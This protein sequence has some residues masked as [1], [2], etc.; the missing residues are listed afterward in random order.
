MPKGSKPGERR[1]GRQKGTTN[2]LTKALKDM[3]LGALD[4]AGGEDYLLA[5]AQENPTAFLALIGKVLPTTLE[6]KVNG[7]VTIIA[8]DLDRCL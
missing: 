3:I 4:K 2:K 5:Q 8:G 1:G 6:G 7:S